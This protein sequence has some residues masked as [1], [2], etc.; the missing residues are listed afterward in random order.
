MSS[1]EFVHA[2]K[3]AYAKIQSEDQVIHSSSH[4]QV[5]NADE[6]KQKNIKL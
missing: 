1:K 5:T 4:K 3:T 6:W 2:G